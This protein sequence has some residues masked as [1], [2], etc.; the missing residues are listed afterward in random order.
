LIIRVR[1]ARVDTNAI[2]LPSGEK[3]GWKSSDALLV[4]LIS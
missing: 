2:E 4:T 1:D 3:A